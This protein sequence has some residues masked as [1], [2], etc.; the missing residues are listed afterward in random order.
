MIAGTDPE[1]EPDRNGPSLFRKRSTII[2]A[3]IAFFAVALCLIV[4]HWATRPTPLR[5]A[6]ASSLSGPIAFTGQE[7]LVATQIYLDEVN[8]SGGIDGHPVE[9][10]VFDDKSSG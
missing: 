8:R 5:I 10:V 6:L 4:G 9:L 2:W 1:G 7:S 3:C